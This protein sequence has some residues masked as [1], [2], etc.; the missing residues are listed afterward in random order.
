MLERRLGPFEVEVSSG[1]DAVLLD[2]TWGRRRVAKAR[3]SDASLAVLHEMGHRLSHGCGDEL[4][5][6]EADVVGDTSGGADLHV[7]A[8][9]V[10]RWFEI[11]LT[12]S[13]RRSGK[14]VT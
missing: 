5:F 4:L 7:R 13:F 10:V 14:A 6:S 12:S 9:L 3:S 11:L 8:P 2:Q 1:G